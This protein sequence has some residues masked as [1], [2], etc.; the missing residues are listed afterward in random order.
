MVKIMIKVN[1]RLDNGY[2]EPFEYV[3]VRV[4]TGLP[5]M[6]LLDDK[7]HHKPSITVGCFSMDPES[8]E[9]TT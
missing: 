8:H 2:L 7:N 9:E 5:F 4:G 3:E 1:V 6:R